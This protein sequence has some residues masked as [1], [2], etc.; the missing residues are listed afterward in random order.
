MEAG[1]N[2]GR[3]WGRGGMVLFGFGAAVWQAICST[4]WARTEGVRPTSVLADPFAN[5]RFGDAARVRWMTTMGAKRTYAAS[6]SR[7]H[8]GLCVQLAVLAE[9]SDDVAEALG[10][11]EIAHDNRRSR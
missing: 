11:F 5:V 10:R 9:C 8:A 6:Q 1:A 2:G 7:R 4:L 3:R